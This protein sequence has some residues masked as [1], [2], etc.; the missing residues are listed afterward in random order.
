M[1]LRFGD[2]AQAAASIF[3]SYERGAVDTGAPQRIVEQ[4]GQWVGHLSRNAAIHWSPNLVD[5]DV[6]CFCDVDAVAECIACGDPVCLAHGHISHRAEAICDECVQKQVD[7]REKKQRKNRKQR[8]TT[9]SKDA[10]VT[11]AFMFLGVNP[12][13][14]WAEVS[15]AYKSAASANHPDKF[16]GQNRVQAEA[17]LKNINAAFAILKA[18]YEKRA[19]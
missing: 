18:H 7:K 8:T 11:Q 1:G 16:Q 4:L 13:A 19:A 14:S 10:E 12:G 17:R 3:S 9:P 5:P 6:C 2:F 15:A